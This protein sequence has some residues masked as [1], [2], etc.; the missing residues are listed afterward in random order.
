VDQSGLYKFVFHAKNYSGNESTATG[1]GIINHPPDTPNKPLGP[2][3]G[4]TGWSYTYS[5]SATDNDGDKVQYR[6]DW[7]D[8][9]PV[10]DW[11]I[12]VPSGD[13][14]GKSHTWTTEGVYEVTAQA[15]DEHGATSSWSISLI[16]QTE[17]DGNPKEVGV[18]AVGNI[19][20]GELPNA[21]ANSQGFYDVLVGHGYTGR[22]TLYDGN[23]TESQFQDPAKANSSGEDYAYT[24]SCDFIYFSGHGSP[25]RFYTGGIMYIWLD[26]VDLTNSVRWGD[27]DLEWAFFSTCETLDDT[28][29][30]PNGGQIAGAFDDRLHGICGFDTVSHDYA[31][32]G[33]TF[34]K[35][36][37]GLYYNY[38]TPHPIGES[39]RWATKYVEGGAPTEVWGA[40][41]SGST[42]NGATIFGY[43]DY[44]PG[45]GSG[46]LPDPNY[47]SGGWYLLYYKW[48]CE[49]P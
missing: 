39:W 25:A 42:N 7:G 9:T 48:K 41:L 8:G 4:Y 21:V 20:F 14:A 3:S 27:V 28:V 17:G 34:A 13:I 46:I 32:E 33:E 15:R 37:L 45:F 2:T 16:V 26:Y 36:A 29:C 47:S 12:L 10:S 49:W 44:M 38:N 11:T 43:S 19:T 40:W 35:Y 23:V 1:W 5:T 24:D 22:F 30:T 6:F 31:I 18:W